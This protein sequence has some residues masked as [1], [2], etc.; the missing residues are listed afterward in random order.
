MEEKLINFE[1]A[2]LAKEKGFDLLCYASYGN[3]I[4]DFENTLEFAEKDLFKRNEN[5]DVTD[6]YSYNTDKCS[7]RTDV[8]TQ[9]LLQKWLREKYKIHIGI[10]YSSITLK[11][12]LW[13]KK[14]SGSPQYSFNTYEEALE[15][16]LQEALKLIK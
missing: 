11:Y 5:D 7:T 3:E 12:D 1:T 10:L 2:K 9:S 14:L 6:L 4:I 8:P 13:I 15:K 16:S